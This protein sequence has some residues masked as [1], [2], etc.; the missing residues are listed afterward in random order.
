MK[1]KTLDEV[2][3]K[4]AICRKKYLGK[5]SNNDWSVQSICD[6]CALGMMVGRAGYEDPKNVLGT[7]ES[8]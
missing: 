7:V 1:D 8:N 5:H 4:C 6:W 2:E 3:F